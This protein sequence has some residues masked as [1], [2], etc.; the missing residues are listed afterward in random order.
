MNS[1]IV[2]LGNIGKE[3]EH[4]R[5]N[6]GFEIIDD[7]SSQIDGS[8]SLERHGYLHKGRIKG[9]TIFL[10]KPTTFV[11]LSGKAINYWLKKAKIN[12]ENMLVVLDDI[13]L[14]FGTLR[15]RKKGN[16]GGH[17]GLKNI[18]EIIGTQNYPRLRFGI[19]DGFKKGNQVT[20]VLGEWSKEEEKSL[21]ERKKMATNMVLSFCTNGIERTM[22][23][24]NNK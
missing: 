24:Y 16:D 6:I 23:E 13:A 1:L 17:N 11:N 19:G 2:G 4:S 18:N 14:P 9:R 22:S 10:L 20:F 12:T 21:E 5:H 15:M 7:L 3:Y 8:F